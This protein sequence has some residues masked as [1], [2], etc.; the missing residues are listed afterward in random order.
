MPHITCPDDGAK[1]AERIAQQLTTPFLLNGHELHITTSIG[2]ALY[3]HDGEDMTTLLQNADAAMYRAKEQGR[4]NY[5]FYTQDLSTEASQRLQME[6]YLHQ[7]LE[8]QEFVVYYQPQ[9]DVV[10]GQVVQMEALLR[11][12]HPKLGLLTPPR[13]VPWRRKRA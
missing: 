11:W 1:I 9:I 4:N 10:T 12:H 8:R 2:I 5:Q 6:S 3:P 13:F 7:A